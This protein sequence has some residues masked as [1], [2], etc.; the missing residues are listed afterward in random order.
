MPHV[1]EGDWPARVTFLS[2]LFYEHHLRECCVCDP[3]NA[4]FPHPCE[5]DYCASS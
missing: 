5:A 1:A 2:V 3:F 4:A